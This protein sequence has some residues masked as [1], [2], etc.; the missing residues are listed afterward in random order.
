ML[1]SSQTFIYIFQHTLIDFCS[2]IVFLAKGKGRKKSEFY[3]VSHVP[4]HT[5][6]VISFNPCNNHMGIISL[7]PI[8]KWEIRDLERQI[9]FNV[10]QLESERISIWK[11]IWLQ[12][13]AGFFSPV[14][15]L[16]NECSMQ[17]WRG[18]MGK[19]PLCP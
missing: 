10:S 15:T 8:Y 5:T 11:P 18:G 3:C 14:K 19:F 9:T 12:I 1:N 17:L 6:D 4:R 13:P 16:P 7:F 2:R